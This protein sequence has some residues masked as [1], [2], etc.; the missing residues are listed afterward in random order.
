MRAIN[1]CF[2]YLVVLLICLGMLLTGCTQTEVVEEGTIEVFVVT[3]TVAADTTT[4]IEITGITAKISE[5]KIRREKVNE[6]GEEWLN[7]Y[8]ARW[9]LNLLQES[10]QQ[11][12]LA[13]MDVETSGYIQLSMV[14]ERL[15]VTLS[16]GSQLVI[17]PEAPFEFVGDFHILASQITTVVFTFEIDKSV[18]IEE[19]KTSIKPIAEIIWTI[20]HQQPE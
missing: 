6:G 13:F 17:A 9:P 16:D 7:L 14:L 8:V 18:V 3:T 19:N 20:R 10:S 12:F 11:Q 4:E 5:I 2:I 15:D 1:I